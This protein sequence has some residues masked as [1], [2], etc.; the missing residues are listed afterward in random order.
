[1]VCRINRDVCR[2]IEVLLKFNSIGENIDSLK[3]GGKVKMRGIGMRANAR[4][5]NIDYGEN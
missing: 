3:D 5:L 2:E 4:I 1:M